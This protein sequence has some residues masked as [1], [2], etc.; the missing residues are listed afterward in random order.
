MNYDNIESI[1]NIV[2][3]VR[4]VNVMAKCR[5]LDHI[6]SRAM[7]YKILREDV[8][9]TYTA[10]AEVFGKTHA[11]VRHGIIEFPYMMKIDPRMQRDYY[12][13]QNTWKTNGSEHQGLSII[14]LKSHNNHLLKEVNDLSLELF[15]MKN[16]YKKFEPI[17]TL[18][19][20]QVPHNRL[21]EV[22]LRVSTLINKMS[23]P[24]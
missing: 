7:C 18:L 15:D 6:Q 21:E 3:V 5:S 24:I 19:K 23:L 8:G 10:I 20:N 13:V 14:E 2:R 11:T 22:E 16:K 17:I 4:G 12:V 1:I 9:M